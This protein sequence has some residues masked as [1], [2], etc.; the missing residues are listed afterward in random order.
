MDNFYFLHR[1]LLDISLFVW[2]DEALSALGELFLSSLG[3]ESL[4]GPKNI[5]ATYTYYLTRDS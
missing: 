2:T 4:I 1:L 3:A 5:Y